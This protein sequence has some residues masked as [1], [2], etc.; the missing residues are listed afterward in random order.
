MTMVEKMAWLEET[1][2]ATE[3]LHQQALRRLRRRPPRGGRVVQALLRDDR[4]R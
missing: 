4:L 1:T 2:R 3:H